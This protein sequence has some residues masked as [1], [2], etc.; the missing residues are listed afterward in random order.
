MSY[1][2]RCYHCG[3]KILVGDEQSR[4]PKC[5]AICCS[6]RCWIRHKCSEL[7]QLL[8]PWEEHNENKTYKVIRLMA[9]MYWEGMIEEGPRATPQCYECGS[10]TELVNHSI[11]YGLCKNCFAELRTELLNE[12]GFESESAEVLT[13][14]FKIFKI[15]DNRFME[16]ALSSSM[17]LI[18]ANLVYKVQTSIEVIHEYASEKFT[19]KMELYDL[20]IWY[21]VRATILHI[22]DKIFEFTPGCY[23]IIK[24]E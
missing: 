7:P 6:M 5:G 22:E 11:E 23:L 8:A 10:K 16:T 17:V 12:I 13:S 9:Q 19:E 21:T 2:C 1:I 14:E 15:P 24:D 20:K 3:R 18:I 4:C